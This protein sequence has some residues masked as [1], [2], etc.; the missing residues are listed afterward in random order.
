M[1]SLLDAILV[2][3]AVMFFVGGIGVWQKRKLEERE[4][5]QS[6]EEPDTKPTAQ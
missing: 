3:G 6:A 5:K 1:N 2:L 4:R